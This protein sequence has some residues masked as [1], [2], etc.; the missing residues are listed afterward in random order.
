MV[1]DSIGGGSL[2][3]KCVN[4]QLAGISGNCSRHRH[5]DRTV[6]VFECMVQLY[7]H[8]F[9]QVNFVVLFIAFELVFSYFG[10]QMC[11]ITKI[12]RACALQS[13]VLGSREI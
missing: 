8:T 6:A 5:A 3:T 10:K 1:L 2:S 13:V 11:N 4:I 12:L 9:K 7:R